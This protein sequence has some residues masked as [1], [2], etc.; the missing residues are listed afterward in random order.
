LRKRC[1]RLGGERW[2]ISARFLLRDHTGKSYALCGIATDITERK[3]GESEIRQLN[4]L[5]EKRVAERTIA[6]VQSNDQLKRA[7]ERLRKRNEQAQKHRDVLLGLAH[8]DKSDFTKAI[9]QICSVSAA[10]LEVGRVSY[11]SLQENG[12]AIGCEVLYLP[13]SS[14]VPLPESPWTGAYW[15]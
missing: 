13:T 14:K 5:L 12:S 2:V 7:E 15:I 9:R 8:S 1:R 11:W 6:L 10:T 3:R 4:T